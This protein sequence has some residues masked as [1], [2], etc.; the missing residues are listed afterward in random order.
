MWALEFARSEEVYHG[1]DTRRGMVLNKSDWFSKAELRQIDGKLDCSSV[2]L[3][4][5]HVPFIFERR[6]TI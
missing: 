2:L 5:Y 4:E 1:L 6:N 3:R